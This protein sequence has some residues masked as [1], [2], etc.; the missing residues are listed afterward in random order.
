MYHLNVFFDKHVRKEFLLISC[1]NYCM[2]SRLVMVESISMLYLAILFS[3]R[4]AKVLMHCL[5]CRS[6]GAI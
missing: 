4:G 6:T 2:L 1:T 3:I 5:L